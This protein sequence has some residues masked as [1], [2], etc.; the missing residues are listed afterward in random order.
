MPNEHLEHDGGGEMLDQAAPKER[1]PETTQRTLHLAQQLQDVQNVDMRG[2]PVP[3][4]QAPD[5][6][7]GH[8]GVL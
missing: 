1:R 6:L 2:L 7:A 4:D 3:T 8:R 5:P